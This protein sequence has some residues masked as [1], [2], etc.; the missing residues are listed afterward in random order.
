MTDTADSTVMAILEVYELSTRMDHQRSAKKQSSPCLSRPIET[1]EAVLLCFV[2]NIHLAI[3]FDIQVPSTE[4]PKA[5]WR[6][7]IGCTFWPA[8]RVAGVRDL[9]EHSQ[10]SSVLGVLVKDGI[11]F[12]LRAM[13]NQMDRLWRWDE[14]HYVFVL[15]QRK[16]NSPHLL[17]D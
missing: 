6:D 4:N 15:L 17:F 9:G 13:P 5:I 16:M 8:R 7:L 14:T 12:L 2:S 3:P 10:H 1:L 11:A